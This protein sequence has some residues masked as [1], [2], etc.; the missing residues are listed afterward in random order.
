MSDKCYKLSWELAG[1][2][3]SPLSVC[4]ACGCYAEQSGAK[5]GR[6]ITAGKLCVFCPGVG[7]VGSSDRERD[8]GGEEEKQKTY[9]L[10]PSWKIL[11]ISS[12]RDSSLIILHKTK[13]TTTRTQLSVEGKFYINSSFLICRKESLF[14]FPFHFAKKFLDS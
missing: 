10:L 9:K 2:R 7:V 4:F 13:T 3:K 8:E 12:T 1:F 14:L 6:R 5:M 11:S